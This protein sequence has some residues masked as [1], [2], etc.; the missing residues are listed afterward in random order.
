MSASPPASPAP[1]DFL[2]LMLPLAARWRSLLLLPLCC[3][4]LALG[5]SFLLP[6]VYTAT[7]TFM[8]PQQSSGGLMGALSSLGGLA[9]LAGGAVGLKNSADQYVGLM[10]SVT[11]SDRI[12]AQFKL[13]EVYDIEFPS[14]LRKELA[15]HVQIS[16]GKKDGL[17]S[18]QVED[19]NAERAA[20]MANQYVEELRRM[21]SVLAV[22]EAQQRRV[23]FEKQLQD[24]KAQLARAQAGLQGSGFNPGA[25]KTEPRAAAESYARLRAETTA[26][27]VKLQTLRG[28]LADSSAEV[29]QQL[30]LLQALREQVQQ[31]EKSQAAAQSGPVSADYISRYRDYK[32]QETL[33]ELMAKQYELARIDESREAALIQVVDQAHPPER[34]SRPRRVLIAA[35]A[36][37]LSGLGYA[38][39]LVLQDRWRRA[40]ADPL[41]AARLQAVAQALRS[42]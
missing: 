11:V 4:V 24:T 22:T 17:I 7:T 32:Y 18:V 39:F 1:A 40:R 21:T 25:L 30:A 13:A 5:G 6:P 2:D 26:A 37:L 36:T 3:G 29:R 20:A 38:L 41:Q 15:T 35:A 34:R 19:N 28:A 27:E 8:A 33:F 12:I 42:R 9:G 16:V 14:L 23:F 31:L 10:Q